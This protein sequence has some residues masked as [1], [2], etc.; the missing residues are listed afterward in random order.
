VA[1]DRSL[2]IGNGICVTLAPAAFALDDTLKAMVLN[3][4]LESE[5]ALWEAAQACPTQ[6]IYLS[7]D[8]KALYP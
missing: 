5:D 8:D 3:P 4:A 6:A 7:A 1:V 2:C